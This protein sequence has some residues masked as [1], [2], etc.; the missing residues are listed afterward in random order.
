MTT[1]P[2]LTSRVKGSVL[3]HAM[4]DEAEVFYRT[5]QHMFKTVRREKKQVTYG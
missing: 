1:E 4:V 2:L 3:Y 5:V